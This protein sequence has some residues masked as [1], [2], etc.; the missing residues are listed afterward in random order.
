[1]HRKELPEFRP[2]GDLRVE[3]FLE[4]VHGLVRHLIE[5]NSHGLLA[6]MS[7]E[8]VESKGKML[9]PQFVR[10]LS[11]SLEVP[12]HLTLGWAACC[13][14]LH[15][16]TLI[17]DD[18]QDGDT[19]RRGQLATWVRYGANQAINAGDFFLMLAP[20][21]ILSCPV[22]SD[23][24]AD[25]VLL[26]S[27]MCTQIAA[28]Q[29]QEIEL[30]KSIPRDNLLKCY[31]DCI[32]GKTS[33]LFS[34]LAKGVSIVAGLNNFELEQVESVFFE[35]GQIFQIQDDILDLYGDKK[36]G[37]PGCDIKEGKVSF[38]VA[39]H[40]AHHPQ[41]YLTLRDIL[42]KPREE[43]SDADIELV[44]QMLADQQT[45]QASVN[46][47]S[48]QCTGLLGHPYLLGH[49]SLKKLVKASLVSILEP[50]R[51]L[52]AGEALL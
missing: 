34:G 51:H 1:M 3:D 44:R 37:E 21:G 46:F 41:D 35:L 17:H 14:I 30:R 23:K 2:S 49:S 29:A 10:D 4:Q 22:G 25:L 24:Q 11:V 43:T 52:G 8:L 33:R 47:L 48:G 13:E 20:Q 18:L 15:S 26:L 42:Q 36:R 45:L 38:L 40:M 6:K 39:N 32:G 28:G 31:F 50:I 7:Q 19:V 27:K 9:R 12:L 16:A 5:L